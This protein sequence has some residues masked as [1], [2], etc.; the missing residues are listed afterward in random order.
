MQLENLEQYEAGALLETDL[1]IVGSGPAGFAIAREFAGTPTRVLVLESGERDEQARFEK[2]NRTEKANEPASAAQIAWRSDYHGRLA[3]NWSNDGQ[4]FGVRNRVFGGS[5]HSWAGKSA[6]F[7]S[8]DYKSRLWIANSGWPFGADVLA[9]FVDRAA[10]LLNLGPNCY[11]EKLW[12]VIGPPPQPAFDDAVLKPFFWQ[13]SR[14][15]LESMDITR[16]APEFLR[17]SASN[18]QVLVNATV[19]HV[20]TD[21]NDSVFTGL[22]IST[23]E[24]KR[25]YVRAK[26]AVLAAGGIENPRLLLASNRRHPDGVGN[27]E[28]T[29]GR[30]L[31]DHPTARIGQFDRKSGEILANRFGFYGVKGDTNWH[32][33]MH[34]V[35]LSETF[36][37]KERLH[38]CALYLMENRAPDDPW[39]A[40]KRLLR[41]RSSRP[42]AD[43]WAIL[44]SPLLLAKGAAMIA[45]SSSAVPEKLRKGIVNLMTAHFPNFVVRE[46]QRRGVPHKLDGLFVEAVT[47][48]QPDPDSR[49]TLAQEKD[50]LGV[51]LA[52]ID[53]RIAD[54]EKRTVMRLARAF[55]D[56]LERVGMPTPT[57]E[58]WIT[59]N[60]PD[61]GVFIDL[62]HP[63]G[64]TRMSTEPKTGV[65]DENCRVHGVSGLYIAGSSVFPTGSHVNPTLMLVALSIRLAD[66]LKRVLAP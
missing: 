11:D 20:D 35:T 34:G 13:F 56:E 10:S 27:K 49:I 24:G 7:A 8:A 15:R 4:P 44:S 66:H 50:R 6:A 48:Q 43:L 32:M 58:N 45:F 3:E 47:E 2:L 33:Y 26:A 5:S 59:E 62:G 1:V 14:S 54:R 23:I 39:G 19:T 55:A 12:D 25:A 30:Y 42:F 64:A 41:R 38:N 57:L 46:Y 52:R 16:I 28:D 65:V 18:I 29:V 22:E 21:D 36:L 40:A 60:R 37:Q 31:M 61:D 63:I 17:L 51:P 9:P 53:W